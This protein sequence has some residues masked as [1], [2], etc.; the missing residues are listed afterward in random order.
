MT[1]YS[2]RLV[3]WRHGR[4]AWNRDGRFQG[5]SDVLLSEAGRDEAT[6]A[7][8]AVA[9]L[10]PAAL[11]SS[12][13][14]RARETAQALA[15][16]C[17]LQPVLD[18]RLREADLG[19]WEGLTREEAA[20]RYPEEYAAW[21]SGADEARGGGESPTEVAERAYAAVAGALETL[22]EGQALV[23]VTHGATGRALIGRLLGLD[24]P[25]WR[26]LRTLGHARWAV[27]E[28]V[29]SGWRLAEYN[30]RNRRE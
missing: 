13:A 26:V 9:K 29:A 27:L 10:E 30:A 25:A 14:A 12:D 28:Q 20:E 21:R 6:V 4:T 7:A 22:E 18:P 16:R 2:H 19:G 15:E 8:R 1:S 5:R 24:P 23:T 17:G 3:V 11:L